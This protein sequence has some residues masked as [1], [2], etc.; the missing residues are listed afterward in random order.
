MSNADARSKM[1]VAF[2]TLKFNITHA[3]EAIAGICKNL[4]ENHELS[5]DQIGTMWDVIISIAQMARNDSRAITRIGEAD[6]SIR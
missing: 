5:N 6:Q 3:S 1:T 2:D 4:Q